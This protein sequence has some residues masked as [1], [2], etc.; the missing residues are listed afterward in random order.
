[1]DRKTL[2]TIEFWCGLAATGLGVIIS[3]Y[4]LLVAVSPGYELGPTIP[5]VLGLDLAVALGAALDSQ[6][7]NPQAMI[8]G[9]GLL[10]SGAMPLVV[11]TIGLAFIPLGSLGLYIL[12]GSA[13]A[14]VAAVAGSY[15]DL[16]PSAV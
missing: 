16:A 9:L 13:L 6:S 5:V 12:P 11:L 15:A 4:G 14:L 2:C 1:M 3:G 7:T 8:A 10:W